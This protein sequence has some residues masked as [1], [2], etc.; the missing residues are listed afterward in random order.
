MKIAIFGL[1]LATSAIGGGALA[2]DASR[3]YTVMDNSPARALLPSSDAVEAGD[4]LYIA[5]AQGIDAA[6]S[7]VPADPKVEARLV[8][9]ALRRTLDAAG[10]AMDDLVAVQIYCSNMQLYA[11]FNEVYR[12]YFHEQYPARTFIGVSQLLRGAHFEVSATARRRGLVH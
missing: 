1:L 7:Q 12:D 10:Y 4:T 8:M 2:A 6:T 3:Q 11:P 9:E 5:G